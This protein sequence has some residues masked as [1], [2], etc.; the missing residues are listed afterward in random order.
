MGQ[1]ACGA[2]RKFD[3]AQNISVDCDGEE[4]VEPG[5]FSVKIMIEGPDSFVWCKTYWY[6][7][8]INFLHNKHTAN[9][10]AGRWKK[11]IKRYASFYDTGV[12][13][14]T[15]VICNTGVKDNGMPSNQ[16]VMPKPNVIYCSFQTRNTA[17]SYALMIITNFIITKV[18]G[19]LLMLCTVFIKRFRR[20]NTLHVTGWTSNCC[21]QL[22]MHSIWNWNHLQFTETKIRCI[23]YSG[24]ERIGN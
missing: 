18:F 16:N 9:F 17:F 14:P 1:D 22:I 12:N 13:N 4:S 8:H 10:I 6:T 24:G 3:V 5:T 2:Y 15:D 23:F 19:F 20:I 7:F 21:K 11:V